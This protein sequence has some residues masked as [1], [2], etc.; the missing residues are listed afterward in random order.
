MGQRLEVVIRTRLCFSGEERQLSEVWDNSKTRIAGILPR[1]A[2]SS[3]GSSQGPLSASSFQ[4]LICNFLKGSPLEQLILQMPTGSHPFWGE[5]AKGRR[6]GS[7]SVRVWREPESSLTWSHNLKEKENPSV[8]W[9]VATPGPFHPFPLFWS[10]QS[11]SWSQ[12]N[13]PGRGLPFYPKLPSNPCRI[14][15]AS[16]CY[17]CPSRPVWHEL[18]LLFCWISPAILLSPSDLPR[19]QTQSRATIFISTLSFFI[20]F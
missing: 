8:A 15:F 5:K 3:E 12:D 14:G 4:G 17:W 20:Q 2:L 19:N 9:R 11:I 1:V 16:L 10:P 7:Q 13:K 18:W 6:L